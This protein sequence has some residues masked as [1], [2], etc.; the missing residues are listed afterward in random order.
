M[1]VYMYLEGFA[2]GEETR[3]AI[4]KKKWKFAEVKKNEA[5][6]LGYKYNCFL[7]LSDF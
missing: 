5:A 6:P 1:Y 4:V 7:I 3:M 2:S